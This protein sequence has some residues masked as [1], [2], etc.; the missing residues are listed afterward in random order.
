MGLNIDYFYSLTP[1]EFN[2]IFKGYSEK[3]NAQLK[4]SWE[5]TR[6]IAYHS[7]MWG[8]DIPKIVDFMPFLWEENEKETKPKPT[9]ESINKTFEKWDNLIFEK[10][11]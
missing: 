5:Q 1:R 9:R 11:E 4:L 7:V 6:I 8:K 3:E 2:N 10:Q